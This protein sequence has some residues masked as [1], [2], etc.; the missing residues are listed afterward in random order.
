MRSASGGQQSKSKEADRVV[1]EH[2]DG[3]QSLDH[4]QTLVLRLRLRV[5]EGYCPLP[6]R[7]E[8]PQTV[9]A[10]MPPSPSAFVRVQDGA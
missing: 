4:E 6:D 5:G 1:E 9:A 10:Q 7:E 8:S 2:G 3:L